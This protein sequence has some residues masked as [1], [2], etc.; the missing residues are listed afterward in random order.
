MIAMLPSVRDDDVRR[1][2]LELLTRAPGLMGARNKSPLGA[3][4]KAQSLG[5]LPPHC[6]YIYGQLPLQKGALA[7]LQRLAILV[8]EGHAATNMSS[9][10]R[11]EAVRSAMLEL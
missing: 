3:V 2:L 7:A 1:A 6:A 4:A 5:H 10:G 11:D 8:E 9:C